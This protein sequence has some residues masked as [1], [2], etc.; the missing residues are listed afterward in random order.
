MAHTRRN[1]PRNLRSVR[2]KWIIGISGFIAIL[3]IIVI[4]MAPFKKLP[5][6]FFRTQGNIH[7]DLGQE[8][9]SGVCQ[10]EVGGSLLYMGCSWP[11]SI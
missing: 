8:L 2:P 3:A 10:P 11:K 6:E 9:N 1:S 4:A 7:I 5:G